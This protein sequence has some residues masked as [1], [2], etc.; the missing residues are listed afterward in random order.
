[1]N[2]LKKKILDNKISLKEIKKLY[3]KEK[4][5]LKI[6]SVQKWAQI[7]KLIWII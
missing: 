6:N 1:M 2:C 7:K 5:K 4:L 3:M